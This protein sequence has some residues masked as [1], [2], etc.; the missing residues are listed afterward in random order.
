MVLGEVVGQI[1]GAAAPVDEELAFGDAVFD[2]VEAHVDGFGA[3]LFDSVIG[4]AGGAGVIGL[5]GSGWLGM[6]HFVECGA[7]PDPIFCVVE[8]GTEFGFGGRGHDSLDDGA[9]DVNGAIER[10][11]SAIGI[12]GLGGVF[13]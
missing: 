3:A 2:P 9:V 6:P 12:G 11:W 5:D 4:N 8:E 13:G 10:R 7:E 1:V